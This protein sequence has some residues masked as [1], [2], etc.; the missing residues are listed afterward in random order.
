MTL[1]SLT[2]ND[3]EGTMVCQS[4]SIVATRQVAITI[5]TCVERD[6]LLSY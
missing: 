4:C 1:K 2:L 5:T 3:L 6:S